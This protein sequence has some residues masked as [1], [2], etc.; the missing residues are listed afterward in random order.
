MFNI[1]YLFAKP[2]VVA[3]GYNNGMIIARV[4]NGA[5]VPCDCAPQ[6]FKDN[7]WLM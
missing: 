5:P 6:H 7:N 2:L 1:S 4:E 3:T